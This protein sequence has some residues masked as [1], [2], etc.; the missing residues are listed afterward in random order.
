MQWI[1]LWLTA[2]FVGVWAGQRPNIIFILADDLG[3]NDVSFHGSRQIPTPNID[4]L[5]YDGIILNNYYVQPIC[6]PTRAALLTG[7]HPIHTGL[8]HYVIAN[9]QPY[10]LGLNETIL[11]QYLKK[12]G[13][14]THMVGKWHLGMFANE[15]TPIYRGFDSHLGYYQGK[16]DYWDHTDLGN[17]GDLRSW[18]LDFHRNGQVYKT[19]FGQYSTKVY[20]TETERIIAEHDK[21]KPLFLYLPHQAVHNANPWRP[22]EAPWEFMQRFA[23][24]KHEGRRTFAAMTAVLD[25]SIGNVTKA[26]AARDMLNNSIIVFSTDN[27]GP[28]HGFSMNFANNWPLRG[29]KE[30]LWE[31]GVRASGFLWSPLLKKTSYVS[32]HMIQVIDWLPTLLNAAGFDM[33]KLPPSIDGIDMWNVLSDNKESRRTEMLHNIDPIPPGSSAIRVRDLKLVQ[34]LDEPKWTG[35]YPPEGYANNASEVAPPEMFRS[36]LRL[37]LRLIGR[38]APWGAPVV[39]ECGPRPA[40]ASTNC[41]RHKAP[42]LF[43]VMADPCEFNNLANRFPALVT[44]LLARLEEYNKTAVPTRNLPNDPKGLPYFHGGA[45]VPWIKLGEA[46]V[47]TPRT[48]AKPSLVEEPKN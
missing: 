19:A 40:N 43:N 4:T 44:S 42:C 17:R 28:S 6:T 22:R 10:G 2:M 1:F 12:L 18:G 21:S 5:A 36:D 41:D 9:T 48:A 46:E 7:R 38:R 35:W 27:G 20:T 24:I 14:K 16:G 23:Y 29:V 15:Y 45:W 3:W 34:G 8:Q 39:V 32:Q 25:E 11:P 47:T 33:S 13:Y 37:V 30:T 31:G 26:L